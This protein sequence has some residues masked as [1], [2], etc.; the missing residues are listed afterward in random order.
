[1]LGGFY[2]RFGD[3]HERAMNRQ[4]Q[5]L[6]QAV[7]TA[8]HPALTDVIPGYGTLYLEYDMSRLT[9]NELR[10]WLERLP[11]GAL[12]DGRRHV[13]DVVYDGPDLKTVA[14]HTGLS[15]GEVVARHSGG[16]Y[17]VYAV[18]FTPG[19]AFMGPLA[20][21]LKVPRRPAPRPRVEAG[22]VA[23]TGG[24]TTVYPVASPGGWQLLG[25]TVRHVYA[26]GHGPLFSPGDRVQFRPVTEGERLEPQAPLELLPK[27]PRRPLLRVSEPGL[28]DLVVDAGRF[29]AG[30]FGYARSGPL[31]PRSAGVANRLVGNPAGAA[32]LELNLRGGLYEVL[33]RGVLAV[34]GSGLQAVL[35]GGKMG[36]NSSF[37]V[38]TG[39]RLGFFPTGRGSCGYL[40]LA[41][42]LE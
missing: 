21:D 36:L 13:L 11:E 7:L 15:V 1:M 22:T 26:P 34:A 25:R 41:G 32:L 14:K 35:N 10:A 2:L 6:A 9:E 16:E 23:M 19:L 4:V 37:A 30:R 31:D 12:P 39:D 42:G 33:G 5:R 24:Q 28:L 29:L 20:S 18:G 3:T 38:G 27:A 17:D 8:P 40:A